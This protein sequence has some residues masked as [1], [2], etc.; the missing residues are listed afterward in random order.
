MI[1]NFVEAGGKKLN[2]AEDLKE[3]SAF[4]AN[5]IFYWP[6]I[7]CF[8]SLGEV[9]QHWNW[10]CK[11]V[12]PLVVL[13]LYMSEIAPGVQKNTSLTYSLRT[14]EELQK[15]LDVFDEK[16]R[17]LLEIQADCCDGGVPSE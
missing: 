1:P 7:W 15:K 5:M 11:T 8:G 16:Y 3:P 10:S 6:D 12:G 9:M 13:H 17:L 2:K 14:S 4:Y